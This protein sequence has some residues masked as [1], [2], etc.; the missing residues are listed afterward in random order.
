MTL[1][2]DLKTDCVYSLGY[3]TLFMARRSFFILSVFIW[4]EHPVFQLAMLT[5]SYLIVIIWIN[6]VKPYQTPSVHNMEVFNE[7]CGLMAAV[8]CF[9]FTDF[10]DS[11]NFRYGA[12]TA[13]ISLILINVAVNLIINLVGTILDLR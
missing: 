10:V 13:M 8:V 12:G 5:F 1:Y 2:D 3:N 4:Q 7:C 9:L 6:W 11:A